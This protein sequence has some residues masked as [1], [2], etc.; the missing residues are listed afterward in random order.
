MCM[1][2]QGNQSIQVPGR[3][4]LK[5]GTESH[6]ARGHED[7]AGDPTPLEMERN[8]PFDDGLCGHGDRRGHK[9]QTMLG[10]T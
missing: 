9:V 3:A 1:A 2:M 7:P 4:D 5:R 8:V 10:S 6:L